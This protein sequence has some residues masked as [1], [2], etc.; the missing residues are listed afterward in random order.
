MTNTATNA[1]TNT[2]LLAESR[3]PLPCPALKPLSGTG[4]L[5]GSDRNARPATARRT[6]RPVTGSH[7]ASQP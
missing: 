1:V 5:A 4:W 3:S 7:P 2:E 6:P